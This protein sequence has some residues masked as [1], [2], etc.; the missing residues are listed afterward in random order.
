MFLSLVK[1]A[2]VKS[3]LKRFILSGIKNWQLL[4]K[5]LLKKIIPLLFFFFGYFCQTPIAE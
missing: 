5:S 4:V 1:A 3:D 2:L